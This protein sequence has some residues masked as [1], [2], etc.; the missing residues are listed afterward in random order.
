MGC[1]LPAVPAYG[2][3]AA[4]SNGRLVYM[5]E[6]VPIDY[7]QVTLARWYAQNN[8][9]KAKKVATISANI[10]ASTDTLDKQKATWP[11]VGIQFLPCDQQYNLLGEADWKPFVQHLKDC[12]A[13]AVTFIGT[14][15]PSLEN[16]LE[17]ANQLD[18]HPDWLQEGNF[19]DAPFAAWN[20]NGWAD[21]VYVQYANVPFEHASD[22]AAM[23]QY[24]SIVKGA[25]GDISGLGVNAASAFLLWATAAQSCGNDLTR[26][27]TLAALGGEHAWDG[28]GLS[29]PA[30]VGAN[31]PSQCAVVLRLDGTSFV[32]AAPDAGGSF[33]CDAQNVQKVTGP[34]VD[35]AKL[36]ADR[37]VPAG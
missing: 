5:P 14:A 27:C 21:D 26:D 18:Y 11:S 2:T 36:G 23:E 37:K 17:A 15:N 4:F 20:T 32:Q 3:S 8:P 19:Y 29:G 25:G 34:L 9:E 10:A 7:A 6:P 24:M 31:M 13:E 22:S 28:G 12:G 16:L 35:N 33:L 30:D 1:G